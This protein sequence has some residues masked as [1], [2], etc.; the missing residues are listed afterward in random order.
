MRHESPQKSCLFK[1]IKN[2][3]NAITYINILELQRELT[4][5]HYSTLTTT[6]LQHSFLLFY[7]IN[8]VEDA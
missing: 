3:K 2:K 5:T 8:G 6:R 4:N 1:K 7:C